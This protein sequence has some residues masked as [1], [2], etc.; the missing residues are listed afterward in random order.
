MMLLDYA[1]QRLLRAPVVA[2]VL[3]VMA[4]AQLGRGGSS[5]AVAAAN[6]AISLCLVAAF[7]AWDDLMDRERDRTRHPERIVVRAASTRALVVA[8]A[9]LGTAGV[10]AVWRVNGE[11]SAALLAAFCGVL[12]AWYATRG[13]RSGNGDRILLFKYAVFTWALIGPA[14]FTPRGL[15][16]AIGVY[17]A[18]CLYEWL[19][20]RESLVFSFGGSR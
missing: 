4:G 11:T 9:C 18:A 13:R 2:A 5:L 14:A 6:L 20:D 3:L 15:A 8:A 17:L 19:H 1:R 7:R 10:I 12:A 16:S